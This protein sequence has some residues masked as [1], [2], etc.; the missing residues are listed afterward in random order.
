MTQPQI[1]QWENCY[2]DGWKNL[3]SDAAFSHPA[4]F[5]HS[6]IKRI[7]QHALAD[8]L[9]KPGGVVVDPFGGVALGGLYAMQNGL[10]WVGCELEEKFVGLGCENIVLWNSRYAAHFPNWGTAQIYQGDSRQLASVVRGAGL[11]ISSPPYATGEKGHPSLGSVNK[12][13]WG[14]DGRDIAGRRG[15]NGNYGHTPG[16]LGA[17]VVGSPPFAGNTGGRGEASR[18]GIDAALFDRHGGGMKKG[19]GS[20]P[21]NLDNL[22]QGT[23]PA[24]VI[25]SPPYAESLKPETEEQ[26]RRKQERIAKSKSLYDGRAI[27]VPSAGKA[28]LGGGYGDAP[29]QLG[30]MVVG[31]PPYATG[32]I[33]HN[34]KGTDTQELIAS[35]AKR[36]DPSRGA[37]GVSSVSD[38]GQTTGQLAIESPETF[39][40]AARTIVEQ[41]YLLLPAGGAAVWVVKNY[42]KGGR[43]VDF[44]GQWQALCESCGFETLHIHRAML[45]KRRGAQAGFDGAMVSKDVSRKSFFRRLSERRGSPPIDW[46]TV[47]CMR[48][49]A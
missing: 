6:L 23:P 26:T 10:H 30:A 4:K 5:S 44:T 11:V 9:I 29:G 12:D 27:E 20:D 15:L 22:P 47:L 34:G 3:I 38:Y 35:Q 1:D 8:G 25:G 36:T 7:Y 31:S 37:M 33:H 2:D 41:C 28:A 49:A 14:N 17:M 18:N 16:Q 39:W 42:I 19:T 40:T 13:D 21:A 24:M 45:V 48:K 43:E 32:G 46:E